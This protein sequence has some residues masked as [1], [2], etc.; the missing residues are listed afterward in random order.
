MTVTRVALA[1][2]IVL[3]SVLVA[4]DQSPPVTPLSIGPAPPQVSISLSIPLTLEAGAPPPLAQRPS[5]PPPRTDA[6]RPASLTDLPKEVHAVVASRT[7]AGWIAAWNHEHVLVSR[8]AGRTFARVLD[9]PGD[10]DGVTFDCY[11]NVIVLRDRELGIRDGTRETWQRLPRGLRGDQD[12][13]AVLIGDGPDVVVI[14]TAPGDT[15]LARAAVSADRGAT[16]WYRDLVDYWESSHASGYQ[17]SDG[18]I[19]VALTTADCMS[20]P[21]YWLRI[22]DGVVASEEL[23]S[24]GRVE[25]DGDRAYIAANGQY[26]TKRFGETS[27][28]PANGKRAPSLFSGSVDPAGRIWRID[29]TI[30]G[31]SAW[32]EVV[33]RAD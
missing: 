4:R 32:V 30:D 25:L 13:P 5:C 10:V 11:G 33:E 26:E 22:R 9:G 19:H 27:W 17:A 31:E 29:E 7:N 28:R 21:V 3:L 24:I 20:D 12:D 6:P 23:G 14:A 8:D 2:Q 16:W 18:T 1:L 15:W